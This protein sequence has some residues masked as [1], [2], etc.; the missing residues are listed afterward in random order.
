MIP[1][2][3]PM[4]IHKIIF[5]LHF[6]DNALLIIQYIVWSTIRGYTVQ[7][8]LQLLYVQYILY[9]KGYIS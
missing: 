4:T 6:R 7:L 1:N 9:I 8:Q 2:N 3:P 5:F